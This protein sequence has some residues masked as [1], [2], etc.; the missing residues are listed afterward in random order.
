MGR[1]LRHY[2]PIVDRTLAAD[3]DARFATA[4]E[5]ID[6]IQHYE[7]SAIGQYRPLASEPTEGLARVAAG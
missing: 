5:L 2:Q 4:D 3:R 1:V 7:A 6:N